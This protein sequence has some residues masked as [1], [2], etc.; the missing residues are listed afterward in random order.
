MAK[1]RKLANRTKE[2]EIFL[3]MAQGNHDCR[4]MLIEGESGMGKT[5]LLSRF[6]QQCP[7]EVKYVPFDCKGSNSILA[8][9]SQVADYLGRVQFPTFVKQLRTFGQGSVDFS[10]NDIAAEK[11]SIAIYGNNLDSE[12]QEYRSQQLQT[13]FFHDLERFEHQIVIAL[14]TYQMANE[15]LRDWIESTW[16]RTVERRLKKVVTVVAGQ[17]IPDPNHLV[18]ANECTHF[19]LTPILDEKAWYEFCSDLPEYCELP[20]LAV[21]AIALVAEGHPLNVNQMLSFAAKKW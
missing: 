7:D 19:I 10:E 5:S 17:S 16:L 18:W 20:E 1:L 2:L 11:I 15:S 13:A 21:K 12:A 9:L 14:D 8:F 4:I 6:R 3:Q